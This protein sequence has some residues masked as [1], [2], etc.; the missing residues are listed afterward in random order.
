MLGKR[1]VHKCFPPLVLPSIKKA[2]LILIDLIL[3][4]STAYLFPVVLGWVTFLGNLL[5]LN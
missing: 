1:R 4:Q 2:V 5:A 3:E